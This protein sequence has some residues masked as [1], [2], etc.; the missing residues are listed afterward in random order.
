MIWIVLYVSSRKSWTCSL[1][2]CVYCDKPACLT[3]SLFFSW[4]FPI[5]D[6]RDLLVNLLQLAL[7]IKNIVDQN[8][9]LKSDEWVFVAKKGLFRPRIL[10]WSILTVCIDRLWLNS[11]NKLQALDVP[12][13][14]W[15]IEAKIYSKSWNGFRTFVLKLMW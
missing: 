6:Y 9:C 15:I 1:C 4:I 7:W 3:L 11:P 8:L 13:S 2:S 10:D 14:A 12:L 5:F